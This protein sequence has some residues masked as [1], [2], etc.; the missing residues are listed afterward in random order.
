MAF[1]KTVGFVWMIIVWIAKALWFLLPYACGMLALGYGTYR[2]YEKWERNFFEKMANEEEVMD[3]IYH[4]M[5]ENTSSELKHMLNK[6][7]SSRLAKT[8]KSEVGHKQA[9]HYASN[10]SN[11]NTVRFYYEILHK[12]FIIDAKFYK[13]NNKQWR[14]LKSGMVNWM[15]TDDDH[16]CY[17]EER[18][19]SLILGLHYVTNTPC[20]VLEES[21]L[22]K[23]VKSLTETFDTHRDRAYKPSVLVK[24]VDYKPLAASYRTQMF[25][26][27][28]KDKAA[29]VAEQNKTKAEREAEIKKKERAIRRK[30]SA[31]YWKKFGQQSLTFCKKAS[32]I[33]G[34]IPVVLPYRIGKFFVTAIVYVWTVARSKKQGFCPYKQFDK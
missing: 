34:F 3:L 19:H 26:W 8:F 30:E 21:E 2:A 4:T 20:P 5:W 9:E 15:K 28:D 18:L 22:F 23:H 31:K 32:F 33:I 13:L 12:Q 10:Y 24:S 14:D 16:E 6:H 11:A 17:K 7:F 1:T 27:I 29:R 25:Q